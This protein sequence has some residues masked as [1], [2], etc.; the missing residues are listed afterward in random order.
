MPCLSDYLEP[1]RREKE[2][3]RAAKLYAYA[4]DMFG[5]KLPEK[6]RAK[7]G[8]AASKMYCDK[9]YV[10]QLGSLLRQKR[11]ECPARFNEVVYDGRIAQA[12]DLASWWQEHEAA[13]R[14]REKKERDKNRAIKTV[15]K[16]LEKLTKEERD[17]LWK[18]IKNGSLKFS[19]IE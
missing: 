3:Q 17:V 10:P 7:L 19:K 2:L 14:A 13:D 18:S 12:R 5:E 9:D 11:R 16:A 1:S 6:E 8:V 15:M 4:L